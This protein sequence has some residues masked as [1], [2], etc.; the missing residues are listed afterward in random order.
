M[1][2]L[3]VFLLIVLNGLLAMSELAVVSAK[4]SRLERR[5]E[6]GSAGAR[7]A[8][9]LAEQ[10]DR[11]LSTVQIGI[12]LIGVGTGALGGA[13]LAGPVGELLARIPGIGETTATS[14]AGIVVVIGLTYLSLVIGELV[15]KR[16]ALQ[17]AEAMAVLMSRPLKV[18]A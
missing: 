5:A 17:R 2:F 1:E 14:I 7:V 12:T 18:M 3:I 15:P 9:E 11:F 10:P 8:L 6:E 13:T 4:P 16:V